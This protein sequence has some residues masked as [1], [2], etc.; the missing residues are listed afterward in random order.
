[1]INGRLATIQQSRS[2]VFSVDGDRFPFYVYPRPNDSAGRLDIRSLESNTVSINFGDGVVKSYDFIYFSTN[3]GYRAEFN[4]NQEN[5]SGYIMPF[6][7]YEDSY[8]GVREISI[9]FSNPSAVYFM[10]FTFLNLFKS[11]PRNIDAIHNLE[12]LN[13][14]V[15][16]LTSF[17]DTMN[18]LSM[19]KVLSLDNIGTAISE[20]IPDSILQTNIE[21][22]AISSSVNLRDVYAS[23]FFA[24]CENLG[25][26]LKVLSV[27][28]TNILTL[29][30]N[31][32]NLAVLNNLQ[33][34]SN[35]FETLPSEINEVPSLV[36]LRTGYLG[37]ADSTKYLGS[38][39]NLINLKEL[40]C[41]RSVNL[42]QFI[43]DDFENCVEFKNYT[44]GGSFQTQE[45]IDRFVNEMYDHITTYASMSAGNTAFRQMFI[46]T[47]IADRPSPI[48][49]GIYQQP[50][51]Y[52]QGSNNGTPANQLEKVWV[53]VNQYQTTWTY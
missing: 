26:T 53:L 4:S 44:A 10:N 25:D 49:S 21:N 39:S 40:I 18:K 45:R 36:T 20:R 14:R 31:F 33:I 30:P 37:G 43:P 47:F 12:T 19:L 6:H 22:L 27:V 16:Q 8:A 13:I 29:P 17:P 11:F 23:N 2:L 3:L 9:S 35:H 42:D 38:F 5:Q 51:G 52:V 7:E 28:S 32:S 41:Y 1:M 50:T 24:L 46:L 34:A 15:S 48:P